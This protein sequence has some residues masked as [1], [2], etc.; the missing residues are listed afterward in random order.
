MTGGHLRVI[1]LSHHHIILDPKERPGK[2]IAHD[3]YGLELHSNRVGV[4]GRKSLSRAAKSGRSAVA[5]GTDHEV[6]VSA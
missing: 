5:V 4:C 6:A 3:K 1:L 2:S